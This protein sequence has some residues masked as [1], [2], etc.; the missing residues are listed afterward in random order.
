MTILNKDGNVY[1][2]NGPNPLVKEQQN[3][4]VKKLIFYNFNWEE[5]KF[6][7]KEKKATKP[8]PPPPKEIDLPIQQHF[9]SPIESNIEEIKIEQK[10]ET[11][12]ELPNI[13]YKVLSHCLPTIIENKKDA[14]YGESWTRIKYGKKII[15]PLIL[16]DATDLTFDFWT[17]DPNEQ[18]NIKSI[19]YP[20]AYEVHNEQ[21][22]SYDKVPYDEYR[23][24]KIISK[25]KKEG[26]W[27]FKS[28]PSENQPDFSD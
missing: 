11:N 9:E 21:T 14:F 23:W 6:K 4:D 28:V 12:F 15:F 19:I 24:W 25:E 17:S 2:L 27:F 13:K 18:I 7:Y 1:V 26:G 20:F 3:W 16:I 8:I 22:N 10:Q 5:I